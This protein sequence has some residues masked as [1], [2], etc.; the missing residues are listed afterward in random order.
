MPEYDPE[1]GEE[2][3]FPNHGFQLWAHVGMLIYNYVITYQPFQWVRLT[4]LRIWGAKIGKGSHILR[5]TT[6]IDI[7][8]IKIGQD[9]SI[10]FRCLLDGRGTTG[11]YKERT[12]GLTIGDHVIIASDTQF[13]PGGHDPNS[14]DFAPVRRK[15]Y[16]ED[17]A[18]IASRSTI[19]GGVRIGRGAVVGT[20]SLVRKD[21]APMEMVAGVPAKVIGTRE[22]PLTHETFWRPWFL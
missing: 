12:D 20:C 4:H 18:W 5:G 21:I 15:T 3:V 11:L 13:L 17:Y 7:H 1:T 16:V 6:V 22:A 14:V 10:G 2:W 9:C 8:G 19:E